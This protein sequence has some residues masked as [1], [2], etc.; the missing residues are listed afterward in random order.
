MIQEAL[1]LFDFDKES[2]FFQLVLSWSDPG[3]LFDKWD[4]AKLTV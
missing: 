3:R 2:S 4:N 1:L